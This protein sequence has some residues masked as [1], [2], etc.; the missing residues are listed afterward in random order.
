MP[1]GFSRDV[2]G[3]SDEPCT[4][5]GTEKEA[6][7]GERLRSCLRLRSADR[8]RTARLLC[9]LLGGLLIFFADDLL[10]Y[11]VYL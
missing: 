6:R 11:N 3:V 8:A 1:D 10:K 7:A 4:A 2:V 9:R 5:A